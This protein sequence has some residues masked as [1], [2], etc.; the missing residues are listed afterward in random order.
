MKTKYKVLIP[1]F[2]LIS[3][4]LSSA[5]LFLPSHFQSLD[6]R[7]RDFYF[8]FRGHEKASDDIIIIDIDERSIKE[9]GQWPWER[10]KFAQILTNLTTNNAGL[11][12][13]QI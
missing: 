11:S 10:D 12:L 8:K 13:I 7:V 3:L 1:L 4:A 2:I 6:N 9:L 5:Y